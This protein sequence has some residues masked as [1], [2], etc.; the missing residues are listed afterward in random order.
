[1]TL[2]SKPQPIYLVCG[3]PG[4]GKT[5]VCDQLKDH[6]DYVPHDSYLIAQYADALIK[7]AEH[8]DRPVLGEAPFRI[9]LLIDQ[10]RKEGIQC[11]AYFVIEP[12]HTVKARYEKRE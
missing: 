6:F 10:I 1:M 12:E 4:S 2:M 11:R 3:V 8:S 7:R 5:W 9:S